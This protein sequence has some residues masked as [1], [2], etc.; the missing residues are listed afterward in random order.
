MAWG[1][2]G[3]EILEQ[4]GEF[5]IGR[6]AVLFEKKQRM[7]DYERER[8]RARRAWI[9]ANKGL[10]EKWLADNR[11]WALSAYYRLRQD[12]VRWDNHL[13]RLR[14]KYHARKLAAK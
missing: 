11:R 2:I 8:S 1:D 7:A 6:D 10:Y 5:H 12:P 4:F 9:R 3:V 13:R 14:D